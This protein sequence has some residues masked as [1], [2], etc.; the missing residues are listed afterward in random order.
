MKIQT[1][2]GMRDFYPDE[3]RLQNWLFE[4]WRSVARGFGF[5]EYEGPIFES[6]DLYKLKSGEGIVSELFNFADRG[7]R[8]FAIRPEMTP[9]LARMVAA[10][11][12]SMPRPIKWF[13]IPRMC[14]AERPQRGRLREFFQWNVDVLGSDDS[15]ADAEVVAVG[16]EFLRRVGL[17]PDDVL[18]RYSSRPLASALLATLGVAADRAPVAFDLLDQ[19]E[20]LEPAEFAERWKSHFGEAVAPE[21]IDDLL[22]RTLNECLRLA[23]DSGEAALQAADTMARMA[24][25]LAA[26]GVADFCRFDLRVVRGLA[27]YTG[28]VFEFHA[29]TGGLR[30]IAGGGR[31]DSLIS[32]LDGPNM[33][34][35]GFGMGDVVVVELLRQLDRMPT[36]GEWLDCFVIDADESLWTEALEVASQ[37]RQLGMS[38]DYSYK[39]QN[40]GK[41]LKQAASRG[42]RVAVI[43]GDE[44]RARGEI[45]IKDME[46]GYQ[47]SIALK[48]LLANPRHLM[49]IP[50]P[51]SEN[52]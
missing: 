36:F 15:L 24:G 14:R 8:R 12:E 46:T 44:F 30:A 48:T 28:P 6:L 11:A 43:V 40:I 41:Q 16:I 38:V 7:E 4:Q 9:T 20:K 51:A 22:S 31:Y 25:H 45:G 5:C 10:R 33:S 50:R 26:L 37:L 1:P 34:G 52:C 39:R 47:Q 42:A 17:T 18:V 29:S 27:Y 23:G 3:M 32:L 2:P 13:S 19:R 49:N 35:V 21:Q